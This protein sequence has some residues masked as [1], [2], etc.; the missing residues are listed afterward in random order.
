VVALNGF[1]EILDRCDAGDLVQA[2]ILKS[3]RWHQKSAQ[4][5]ASGLSDRTYSTIDPLK[6]SP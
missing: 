4:Q 3:E 1:H 2:D 5:A 6:C